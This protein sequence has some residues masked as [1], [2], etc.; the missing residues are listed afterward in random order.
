M[1]WL[2]AMA[3]LLLAGEAR[4]QPP[5]EV[6]PPN[7][8]THVDAVYPQSALASRKHADVVLEIV[9]DVDGHVSDH[10][11]VQSGGA[12]LDEAAILAVRQW[13]FEPAKRG[14]KPVASRIR[15]PFH[16]APP[17]P[18]PE[19]VPAQK[20][21][22]E[23]TLPARNAVPAAPPSAAAPAT[24]P[25]AIEEVEVPGRRP[26]PIAGASD[27]RVPVGAL[28][29]LPRPS[30]GEFLKLTPGVLVTNEGGEGHADSLI[31]R[32]F[33]AGEGESMELSV[34][35]V[36]INEPGNFHGNGYADTHFILPELVESVRVLQG[37]FDPHQ[38][39]FAV[40]GSADYQLGLAERGLS[41]KYTVGS[42]ATDRVLLTW[43]PERESTHTF[44]AAEYARS[45]GYGQNRAYRRGSGIAQYEGKLGEHGSY[46]VTGQAYSVVAQSAGVVREDDV[47]AGRIGFYGTYDPNQ[48]QDSS[49]FSLA[50]DLQ[51]QADK[52]LLTQ[53]VFVLDRSLRIR[54]DFTGFVSDAGTPDPRG[55][56]LDLLVTEQSIGARGSARM[57]TEVFGH[58]QELELGYFARGDSVDNVQRLVARATQVPYATDASLGGSLGDVG[59]Y[60]DTSLRALR[61]ITLRGGLRG[62]LFTYL[63]ED[64]CPSASDC[65]ENP[66]PSGNPR[67]SGADG[68]L[69]PRASLL[70]GPFEGFSLVGS[71]GRGV[72]SLA[73]DEVNAGVT[74]LAAI[75]SYEGGVSYART[76]DAGELTARSVFYGTRVNR[77]VVFSPT[78]GRTV[79]TGATTRTGWVGSARLT[80]S[81]YDVAANVSAVRGVVDATGEAIP[82]VPHLMAR[83]D[84][85]LFADLP[86]RLDG[87]PVRGSIG[88]AVSYVGVRSLPFAETSDGYVLVDAA[89]KLRWSVFELGLS[90]TNLF[91]V[92][93]RLSE[94]TFVSDFHTQAQPTLAPARAFT[95]GPPRM[96][97]L[98]L[99][100]TLGG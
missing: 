85:A 77:D 34:G 89:A 93:Y 66:P 67:T 96:I 87:R 23:V 47:E 86:W 54:E 75:D 7:V 81:F 31:V 1:G 30:A 37:P 83:G 40:A 69:L 14:G 53:Q 27:Y 58:R 44:A 28:S 80:G 11:V 8:L 13:T 76:T 4:A 6:T 99:G 68:A 55:T 18:E 78:A 36:P 10:K 39:N 56:A 42:Y 35:G 24:P 46:R 65:A 100:A 25:G 64:H 52:V 29:V 43:G 90:A 3:V 15:I 20:P 82:Y 48:G 95:A 49:R 32:G 72:R 60:A 22:E 45:D 12:D 63:V 70:L 50:A 92:R 91:D 61:W 74:S 62:E 17:E 79:E 9:V 19:L 88:P 84:G 71:Y 94:F 21:G 97:F 16:F 41:A 73:I 57:H 26:P 2:F 51:T 98:S 38:G 33:D 5:A 59:L